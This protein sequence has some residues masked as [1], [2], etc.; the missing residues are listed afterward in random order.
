MAGKNDV[1][2]KL[3]TDTSGVKQGLKE[4]D[5][6]VAQTAAKANAGVNDKFGG[7]LVGSIK[8]INK[9]LSETVGAVFAIIGKLSL[10]GAALGLVAGAVDVVT[11]A[12][13]R[14]RDAVKKTEQ[15]LISLA[16]STQEAFAKVASGL[17]PDIDR[18]SQL[19]R[20]AAKV[21]DE[22]LAATRAVGVTNQTP[23]GVQAFNDRLKAINDE[24]DAVI[25]LIKKKKQEEIDAR[26]T[27]NDQILGAG[28][29]KTEA[30]NK[31]NAR[32]KREAQQAIDDE[33][34]AAKERDRVLL[35]QAIK[36][37]TERNNAVKRARERAAQEERE[38]L[39]NI[40]RQQNDSIG[41]FNLGDAGTQ[42]QLDFYSLVVPSILRS[43]GGR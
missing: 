13:N 9:G 4:T 27:R 2:I 12:L 37:L 34:E 28:V 41:G 7:G 21:R 6:A 1:N 14:K 11:A 26:V 17:D 29:E 33:L 40:A 20:D 18:F 31:E 23:E 36:G 10:F 38:F 3:T 42:A 15:S 35:V 30:D 5:A 22:Q 25:A 8:S 24:Y 43:G 32:K 19:A 16:N 39:R